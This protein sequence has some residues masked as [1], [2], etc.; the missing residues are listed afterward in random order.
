MSYIGEIQSKYFKEKEVP[1]DDRKLLKQN[2][3]AE[4]NKVEGMIRKLS[5]KKAHPSELAR[6]RTS[7]V[8]LLGIIDHNDQV[9]L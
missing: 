8:R 3:Q 6:L 9:H 4:V 2:L 5:E 7:V 1:D